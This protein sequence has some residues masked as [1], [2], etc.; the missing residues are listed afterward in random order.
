MVIF[1]ALR[2]KRTA[3]QQH[4]LFCSLVKHKKMVLFAIWSSCV[5]I[6]CKIFVHFIKQKAF[7]NKIKPDKAHANTDSINGFDSDYVITNRI[8]HAKWLPYIFETCIAGICIC[9]CDAQQSFI[10]IFVI[11]IIMRTI[12]QFNNCIHTKILFIRS[13]RGWMWWFFFGARELILKCNNNDNEHNIHKTER[14]QCLWTKLNQA[15]KN[16]KR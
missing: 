8:C 11:H 15:K 6:E 1:I 7:H 4:F 13:F 16:R 9:I 5:M 10:S 12:S 2:T 14:E 3:A